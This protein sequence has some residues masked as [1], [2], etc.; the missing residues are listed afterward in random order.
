MILHIPKHATA[1][2]TGHLHPKSAL[3]G[4]N[5][6]PG[7]DACLHLHLG[8]IEEP[9]P[10][11]GSGFGERKQ[12]RLVTTSTLS[13]YLNL[14]HQRFTILLSRFSSNLLDYRTRKYFTG[15][16]NSHGRQRTRIR[17]VGIAVYFPLALYR[18]SHHESLTSLQQRL[19]RIRHILHP[20]HGP[21]FRRC[22]RRGGE[23]PRGPRCRRVYLHSPLHQ[24]YRL[25]RFKLSLQNIS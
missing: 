10:T 11:P 3:G 18:H 7:L 1:S 23:S 22:I 17:G 20:R 9:P 6:Q 13:T 16:S 5:G 14:Q 4:W 12:T 21:S 25:Y 24:F 2:G 19:S 15:Q 8:V